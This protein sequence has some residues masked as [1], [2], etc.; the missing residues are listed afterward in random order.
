MHY[1]QLVTAF[2]IETG[3]DPAAMAAQSCTV[4]FDADLQVTF[5]AAADGRRLHLH[6]VLAHAACVDASLHAVLLELHLFGIATD[7]AY[8]GLDRNAGRILLFKTIALD[9][10][11]LADALAEIAAFVDQGVRW[12]DALPALLT[13]CGDVAP[14]S[15]IHSAHDLPEVH[16]ALG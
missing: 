7:G 2:G 4:Q 8:F 11:T 6:A 12:R 14:P 10:A 3:L 16:H 15:S 13:P 5:E 1:S 9:T